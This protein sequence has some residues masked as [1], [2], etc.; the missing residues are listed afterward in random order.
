MLFNSL[1]YLLFLS[2]VFILYWII[3]KDQRIYFLTLASFIFY[4]FWEP[5]YLIVII[6][7][8]VVDYLLAI[9]IARSE[10]ITRKRF[11][12]VIS[13][14]ANLALLISFKYLY[15]FISNLNMLGLQLNADD[16]NFM[17][18]LGISFFTF[19]A[20]SY[21]VDIYRNHFKPEKN[22]IYYFCFIAIGLFLSK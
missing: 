3:N 10:I 17:L 20:I 6:V 4:G 21:N 9:Q 14:V 18:P 19:E 12:L 5:A 11:F 16:Y 7:I 2:I 15:F 13:I 1:S 8:S 22:Y